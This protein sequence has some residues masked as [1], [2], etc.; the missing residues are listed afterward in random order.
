MVRRQLRRGRFPRPAA[1]GDAHQ[2]VMRLVIVGA[3]EIRLVG[4]D[5]RQAHGIGQIDQRGFATAFALNAMTLQLDIK[6]VAEQLR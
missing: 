3:G 6:P 4:R 5:Q 2:R 1:A